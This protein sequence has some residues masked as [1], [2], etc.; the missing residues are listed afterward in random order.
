MSEEPTPEERRALFRVVRGEPDDVEV[1]A[2]TAVL[3]AV[4]ASAGTGTAPAGPASTWTD[5]AARMRAPIAVG[6]HA[7]RT[8]TW[9]R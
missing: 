3:A 8:S 4:A 7:W 5:P 6:P 9:P 2:L 1:A